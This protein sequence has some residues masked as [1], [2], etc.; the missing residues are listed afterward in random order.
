LIPYRHSQT[1]SGIALNKHEVIDRESGKCI[2]IKLLGFDMEMS[3]SSLSLKTYFQGLS[4]DKLIL[5]LKCLL[6][7]QTLPQA[8]LEEACEELEGI[9]HFYKNRLSQVN[10]PPIPV[11]SI[12]GKLRATQ[13]RPPIVLEP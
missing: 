2:E 9:A 3:S 12:R 8:A 11:S 1:S 4:L 10:L 7:I 13:I 5:L 6:I